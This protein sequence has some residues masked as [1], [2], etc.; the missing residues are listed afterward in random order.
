MDLLTMLRLVQHHPFESMPETFEKIESL[1][2]LGF[3]L[4]DIQLTNAM[5]A[6]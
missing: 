2:K 4:P 1:Q 6:K 3:H 5:P